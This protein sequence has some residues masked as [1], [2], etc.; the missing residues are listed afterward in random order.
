MALPLPVDTSAV[1]MHIIGLVCG[2][3]GVLIVFLKNS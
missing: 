1:S 2:A 3:V